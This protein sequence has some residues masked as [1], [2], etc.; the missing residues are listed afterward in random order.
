MWTPIQYTTNLYLWCNGIYPCR[1]WS[2]EQWRVAHIRWWSGCWWPMEP[3]IDR[4]SW[5]VWRQNFCYLEKDVICTLWYSP[6]EQ[7]KLAWWKDV[8][9]TS[10]K[11]KVFHTGRIDFTMF[12]GWPCSDKVERLVYHA[13]PSLRMQEVG[14]P[15]CTARVASCPEKSREAWERGYC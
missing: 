12:I 11:M 15:S 13:R 3:S 8:A 10:K 7:Q 9:F 6:C 5:F 14:C 4:Y 2:G 1:S